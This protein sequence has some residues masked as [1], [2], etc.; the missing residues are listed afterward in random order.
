MRQLNEALDCLEKGPM[1]EEEL[2]RMRRIGSVVYKQGAPWRAQLR[3][4]IGIVWP[5]SR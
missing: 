5:P 1:S 2:E 4:M 3:A